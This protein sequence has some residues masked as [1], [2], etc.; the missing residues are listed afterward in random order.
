MSP[1]LPG[2]LI[3]AARALLPAPPEARPEIARRMITEA[4]AADRYRRRFRKAHRDWGNGTLMAAALAR[5]VAPEPRLDDPDYLDCLFQI[6]TA[7]TERCA[8]PV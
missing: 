7:L 2:D 5:P 1:V 4:D 8:R 6:F 3:A